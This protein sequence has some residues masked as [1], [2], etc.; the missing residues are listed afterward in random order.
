M[1][2]PR[3]KKKSIAE[4]EASLFSN[5]RLSKEAFN[6]GYDLGT[7]GII[8]SLLNFIATSTFSPVTKKTKKTLS[9]NFTDTADKWIEDLQ[10]ECNTPDNA[11]YYHGWKNDRGYVCERDT[12]NENHP[13]YQIFGGKI[14]V[15]STINKKLD[16]ISKE[17]DIDEVEFYNRDEEYYEKMADALENIDLTSE[18]YYN[19]DFLNKWKNELVKN[20]KNN[21]ENNNYH[22]KKLK[23]KLSKKEKENSL[24]TIKLNTDNIEKAKKTISNLYFLAKKPFYSYNKLKNIIDK[25]T[26]NLSKSELNKL[27]EI[28]YLRKNI[29]PENF[30][31]Y[32]KF[33][34]YDP[35]I[36][37]IIEE[38]QVF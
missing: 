24:S 22:N 29:N 34:S 18:E 14:G 13:D 16:R 9:L 19:K 3:T 35:E 23:E 25:N 36:H 20:I 2:K 28:N 17:I 11:E 10:E 32:I 27:S 38:S 1:R 30:E 4:L 5:P 21:E 15:H 7:T 33:A 8:R 26:F 6:R 31:S 37:R 12:L